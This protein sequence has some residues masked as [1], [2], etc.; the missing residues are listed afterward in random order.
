MNINVYSEVPD[1]EKDISFASFMDAMIAKHHIKR[2]DISRITGISQDYLYKLLSGTRH[3]LQRDYILA[4]CK[5]V[6]MNV[7]ETQQALRLNDMAELSDDHP[8][9]Q[10]ILSAFSLLSCA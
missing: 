5:A 3:T 7:E 9:D 2:I 1:T 8:R 4:I 6:E 10:L